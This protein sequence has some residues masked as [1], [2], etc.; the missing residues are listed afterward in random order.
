MR[1]VADGG[2]SLIAMVIPFPKRSALGSLCY[3]I[4]AFATT[5]LYHNIVNVFATGFR[6]GL[7]PCS[8]LGFV[9]MAVPILMERYAIDFVKKSG[10]A[11]NVAGWKM[12]GYLWTAVAIGFIEIR[13]VEGLVGVGIWEV[14]LKVLGYAGFS[15]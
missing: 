3:L 6:A 4:G 8:D 14:D 7:Q 2:G 5:G 15:M 9:Q 11:S 10:H 1:Q 12:F 13:W